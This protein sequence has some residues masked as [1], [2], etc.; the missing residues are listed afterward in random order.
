MTSTQI[1]DS[2]PIS[3]WLEYFGG[4]NGP[5]FSLPINGMPEPERPADPVSLKDFAEWAINATIIWKL[6]GNFVRN[7]GW[8]Y[9]RSLIIEQLQ[10]KEEEGEST[11]E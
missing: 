1:N 9:V 6:N 11:N 7:G 2:H 8:R 5:E 3:V 4:T 10:E